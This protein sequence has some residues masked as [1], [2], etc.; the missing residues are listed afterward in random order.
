MIPAT[1]HTQHIWQE[2][3]APHDV[4]VSP[5]SATRIAAQFLAKYVTMMATA[6]TP[7]LIKEETAY[8]QFPV[9][10]T[11]PALGKVSIIGDIRVNAQTGELVEPTPAY[12]KKMKALAYAIAEH[13]SLSTAE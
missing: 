2:N 12:I 6:D 7:T 9:A 13:F 11:I 3:K 1:Y 8:W 5:Q 10:L 4:Q